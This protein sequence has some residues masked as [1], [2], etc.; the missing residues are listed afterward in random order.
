M[1]RGKKRGCMISAERK[2]KLDFK[3]ADFLAKFVSDRGKIYPRSHTGACA[4]RQRELARAVK[5]ARAAGLL[6]TG[7]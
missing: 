3:D 5:K 2:G 6:K 1:R 4:K 7:G